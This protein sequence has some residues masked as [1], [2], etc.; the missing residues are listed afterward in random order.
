MARRI[1]HARHLHGMILAGI[2]AAALAGGGAARAAPPRSAIDWLSDTVR[3]SPPSEER[4]APS[5]PGT[6]PLQEE[7]AAEEPP[8][9]TAPGGEGIHDGVRFLPEIPDEAPIESAPIGPARKDGVGLVAAVQAGLPPDFWADAPRAAVIARITRSTPLASP[10]LMGLLRRI[11]VAEM[12]PPAGREPPAALLLARVDKLLERGMVEEAQG[13]LER[14]GPEEP[15]LFR[16]W[17]D[18]S[19]LLGQ[20]DRAC[21]ALRLQPGLSTALPARIFC[22]SRTGEYDAAVVTFTTAETLG[23]ISGP[24]ADLIALFLDPVAYGDAPK[25]PPSEPLTPLEFV[26]REILDLPRPESLPLAFAHWDL[27]PHQPWRRRLAAAERLARAHASDPNRMMALYMEGRPPASG[28]VWDRVKMVQ[29]LDRALIAADR[30]KV[31]ERLPP[32]WR[33]MRRAG[34]GPAFARAAAPRLVA[35]GPIDGAEARASLRELL[36]LAHDTPLPRWLRPRLADPRTAFLLALHDGL[37]PPQ[38]P[39]EFG[40]LGEAVASAFARSESVPSLA[41]GALTRPAPS[42]ALPHRSLPAPAPA[43]RQPPLRTPAEENGPE[44]SLGLAVLDG[45]VALSG[46]PP[47]DPV[48]VTRGLKALRRAGFEGAARKTAL[49]LLLLAP[50]PGAGGTALPAAPPSAPA[51]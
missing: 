32:L 14:A 19:L 22:L 24:Q 39:A 49:D 47:L 25:P 42:S 17:F 27:Q 15:A 51:Q 29:A 30:S 50:R 48:A 37:T 16:R 31:A 8:T 28:G 11:L 35:L 13:L 18:A 10:A 12:T 7:P 23:L 6:R 46:T 33:A 1:R 38:P 20:V 34:L 43:D 5:S 36:L 40:A 41:R 2:A 44:A 4:P 45:I 9:M 3:A 26:M 21:S